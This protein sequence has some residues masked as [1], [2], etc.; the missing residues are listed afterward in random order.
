MRAYHGLVHPDAASDGP[1]SGWASSS[2]SSSSSGS[3]AGAGGGGGGGS[4]GGSSGSGSGG[5]GG[6]GAG[7]GAQAPTATALLT[8]TD[9]DWSAFPHPQYPFPAA[10]LVGLVN[11]GNTCFLNAALQSLSNVAPLAAY[12]TEVPFAAPRGDKEKDGLAMP[13][14]QLLLAV[15]DSIARQNPAGASGGGPSLLSYASSSASTP[16]YRPASVL[17]GL[18]R[19]N[20]LFEG[21]AQQD[22]HEALR[23]VLA[24]I[25][26]KLAVDVPVGLYNNDFP[27]PAYAGARAAV[28]VSS[29]PALA[30]ASKRARKDG[31][32]APASSASGASSAA[33]GA[34]SSAAMSSSSSA[35]SMPSPTSSSS[36]A[37]APSSV[38]SL[39][40][41]ELRE[42]GERGAGGPSS[43]SPASRKEMDSDDSDADEAPLGRGG[44]GSLRGAGGRESKAGD[45]ADDDGA[46]GGSP[47]ASW[48]GLQT[49][50]ASFSPRAARPWLHDGPYTGPD[51]VQ[52]SIISDLF[53][54]VFCSR[55]RCSVC[56][57]ESLTYETFFDLSLPIPGRQ[58]AVNLGGDG[59][60]LR[61]EARAW[62]AE[63]EDFDPDAA[64]HRGAAAATWGGGPLS[65]SGSAGSGGG[66]GGGGGGGSG[67]DSD[68]GVSGS[69]IGR[70]DSA[71]GPAG[72]S[73][74]V[75]N[76]MRKALDGGDGAGG[77][78]GAVASS[79]SSTAASTTTTTTPTTSSAAASAAA[80]TAAAAAAEGDTG[81]GVGSGPSK[82]PR[83]GLSTSPWGMVGRAISSV[84][85]AFRDL[86]PAGDAGGDG[87]GF[88][89]GPTSGSGRSGEGPA[90]PLG[91]GDLLYNFFQWEP[92]VGANQ[93][94]CETCRCK[95]DA[96]RRIS[97]AALPEV[98]CVHLKRFSYSSRG[99]KNTAAVA[100]PLSGLDLAPFLSHS[101]HSQAVRSYQRAKEQQAGR[102][103]VR[104]PGGD[105]AA[106]GSSSEEAAGAAGEEDSTAAAQSRG[107]GASDSP[108][109]SDKRAGLGR[110]GSSATPAGPVR[111]AGSG[112]GGSGGG[113]LKGGVSVLP[114]AQAPTT[115]AGRKRVISEMSPEARAIVL[116]RH[117]LA[118]GTTG[119]EEVAA[120]LAGG[121]STAVVGGGGGSAGSLSPSSSFAATDGAGALPLLTAGPAPGPLSSSAS[122]LVANGAGGARYPLAFWCAYLHP[123]PAPSLGPLTGPHPVPQARR[124]SPAALGDTKYDL[125]SVVQHIGGM[126]GGHYIAHAKNRGDARWYTFDDTSVAQLDASSVAKKEGYILFF[127][128]QRPASGPLAPCPLPQPRETGDAASASASASAASSSAAGAGAAT[129]FVSR[130]WFLRYK[131]LACPGPVSN[132]DILCDHGAVKNDLAGKAR[133]LAV[134]LTARQYEA[135]ALAYGAAEPPLRAVTPCAECREEAKALAARRKREHDKIQKVDT[136]ALPSGEGVW[137]IMSEVWLARWRHFIRNE[138]VTD[139]TGRGI[140]PPGPIDNARLLG[141][142][143]RPLP[144]LQPIIHY[145]GVNANVWEF[146]SK[147]YGGGPPLRR[148]EIDIYKGE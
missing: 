120:A 129:Y 39:K 125:V 138:G 99:S 26:E 86:L 21:Y 92:L 85:C 136:V 53:Q 117:S 143:G 75:S 18:R 130:N 55:V 22:A 131:T 148:K 46:A 70:S 124:V 62:A 127:Q 77:A 59:S 109:G 37:A 17:S 89:E 15:W 82:A 25:H 43:A 4:G 67:G 119:V 142:N 139:G 1:T 144:N 69:R 97:I 56:K 115:G 128:R 112:G 40:L 107:S 32:G 11:Q 76:A 134:A 34:V 2:S 108:S 36:A 100:F 38:S 137:Y 74:V 87:G 79:S 72:G 78:S 28:A 116:H 23:A 122:L 14:R 83:D 54:G 13:L 42:R 49:G 8:V 93:Y 147:I 65:G 35:S 110:G 145:R 50:G 58:H 103:L 3:G 51:T 47:S 52:R 48:S 141:K 60:V 68:D 7:A 73:V 123:R 45:A 91:L 61:P 44:K 6:G 66:G 41:K 80:A 90:G 118:T 102:T 101:A 16:V 71:G 133:Q 113:G 9:T 95:V 121:P 31:G 106:A 27:A 146:L 114:A 29:G 10:G 111:G 126:G 30:E 5:G 12:F 81:A 94:S 98:L 104:A 132:A 140:L 88:G 57:T 96:E 64:L 24:D 84:F 135:L 20:A 19:V 33:G 63:N 105:G